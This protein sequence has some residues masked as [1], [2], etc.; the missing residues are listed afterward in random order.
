[1]NVIRRTTAAAAVVAVLCGVPVLTPVAEGAEPGAELVLNV[2]RLKHPQVKFAAAGAS[3][4]LHQL[5]GAAASQWTRWDG[6]VRDVPATE[7]TAGSAISLAGTDTRLW[8]SASRLQAVNLDTGARADFALPDG[9][10]FLRSFGTRVLTRSGAAG[11]YVYRLYS[12]DVDQAPALVAEVA[13]LPAGTLYYTTAADE[14]EAVIRY[15]DPQSVFRFG[16]LDLR[17]GAFRQGPPATGATDAVLTTSRLAWSATGTRG[18][19]WVPRDDPQAEPNT[20]AYT[21]PAD[22]GTAVLGAAGED[23]LLGWNLPDPPRT[24]DG[25][26][27]P[28]TRLS[29]TGA[30]PVQVLAHAAPTLVTS[31]DGT[32]IT[33]G[34]PDAGDWGLRR[35]PADGSAPVLFRDVPYV[36]SKTTALTMAAGELVT[37]QTDASFSPSYYSRRIS[38]Q[39]GELTAGPATYLEWVRNDPARMPATGDGRL[40]SAESYGPGEGYVSAVPQGNGGFYISSTQGEVIDAT[41]RFAV[42]NGTDP[43]RQYVGDLDDGTVYATIERAITPASIWGPKLWTT[44]TQPGVLYA[45]DVPAKKTADT[46]RTA[47]TCVATDVQAVGR[48]LYWSCGPTAA[49]GVYDRTTGK[50]ITVP[51]GQAALADGY[52]VRWDATSKELRLT[53]FADGTAETRTV[54][55]LNAGVRGVNWTVDKF[56]GPMAYLADDGRVHVVPTGV[57][58]QPV[59]VIDTQADTSLS[60]K[61]EADWWDGTWMLS[62]PAASWTLSLKNLTSGKEVRKLTGGATA[63]T[64]ITTRWD[65]RTATGG[66]VPNGRY[67]WTLTAQPADGEGAAAVKSGTMTLSGG[68]AVRHDHVAGEVGWPAD[69]IGDML[70]LN[71]RGELTFH[72]ADGKGKF[73]TYGKQSG[74]GWSTSVKAVP[75]GDVNN[76]RCSDV[77]VRSGDTLKVYKPGCGNAVKPTT[78]NTSLGTGWSKYNL[79]TSP[80]DLTSDGR[81][82]LLARLSSTG[83]I[84]LFAGTSDGKLAA[85]KKIR[86]GWAAYNFIAGAGDLNGDGHGDLLTRHKDGTLYWYAGLGTGQF[87]ERVKIFSGWGGSYTSL[88]GPGDITGD[89]KADLVVRDKNGVLYRN[90]GD[91]KGGFSSKTQLATGWTYVALF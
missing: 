63:N 7:Y 24:A 49:A 18:V 27:F 88:V 79:L 90:N 70:T 84:Y 45:I 57:T 16:L 8:W 44:G 42:V 81:A 40:V 10:T 66:Y 85:G 6:T 3:G 87:K 23:L 1:M 82:D 46:V 69:G 39:N 25:Y 15:L 65:G 80:G 60:A 30:A 20:V 28:L 67:S 56:G 32:L 51:S 61:T 71:T 86:T 47:A 55:T 14:R 34:G 4:V 72:P 41:G 53:D 5:E 2:P 78:A 74:G 91:G 11:A 50:T 62:K 68:L 29:F 64:R 13:G 31:A 48:W 75:F 52:L 36:P 33:A 73:S 35:V 59:S 22:T 76:D 83:D 38:T 17:T 19:R 89:G 77:L 9:E 21:A 37:N 26:G 58:A 12:A 43:A 54:G